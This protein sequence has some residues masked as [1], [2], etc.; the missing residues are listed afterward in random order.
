MLTKL[1]MALGAML[2]VGYVGNSMMGWEWGGTRREVI[3]A[4]AR[5]SPG[6]YRS[7][8]FWHS[9]YQGGK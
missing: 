7:F 1:Y 5:Q 6:G 8:H 2:I 4:S 3:P 9:G